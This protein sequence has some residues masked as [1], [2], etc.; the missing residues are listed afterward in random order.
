MLSPVGGEKISHLCSVGLLYVL[1]ICFRN[2]FAFSVHAASDMALCMLHLIWHCACV[3]MYVYIY[4][5]VPR[6]NST[7]AAGTNAVLSGHCNRFV[8][9]L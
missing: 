8:G 3:Y 1:P 6:Q 9:Y 2:L 7:S 4:V 5:A